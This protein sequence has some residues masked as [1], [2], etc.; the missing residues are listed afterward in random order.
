[1]KQIL[2][3]AADFDKPELLKSMVEKL[4]MRRN[5]S[6]PQNMDIRKEHEA[7]ETSSTEA[8]VCGAI[9][10]DEEGEHLKIPFDS[11]FLFT[12]LKGYN[13]AYEVTWSA[14]LS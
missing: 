10:M 6:K 9:S 14:S 4:V 8:Y 3:L 13:G 7:L 5:E 11:S 12:C 1:M 2:H